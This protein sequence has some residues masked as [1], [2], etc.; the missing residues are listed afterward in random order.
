MKTDWH[1]AAASQG[2]PRVAGDPQQR[3]EKQGPDFLSEPPEGGP[4]NTLISDL[5]PPEL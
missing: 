2:S 1:V 3:G 5:Q 4:A